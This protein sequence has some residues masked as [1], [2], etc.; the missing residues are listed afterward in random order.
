MRDRGARR[1]PLSAPLSALDDGFD[2]A[3][4]SGAGDG[5]GRDSGAPERTRWCCGSAGGLFLLGAAVAC[6]IDLLCSWTAALGNMF[7]ALRDSE[8][9]S[10]SAVLALGALRV[11][12]AI[13]I[14]G[15][16]ATLIPKRELA[17][18]RRKA[19]MA[20]QGGHTLMLTYFLGFGPIAEVVRDCVCKMTAGL[21]E[22]RFR[23]RTAVVFHASAFALPQLVMHGMSLHFASTEI[24]ADMASATVAAGSATV[25]VAIGVLAWAFLPA[26]K[27]IKE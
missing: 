21:Q 11:F 22:G 6:F 14:Y 23:V 18:P 26:A 8:H 5:G 2:S 19:L 4:D 1:R 27:D 9:V 25:L 16:M 20:T 15:T 12:H 10:D 17:G 3:S 13:F 7:A 24:A